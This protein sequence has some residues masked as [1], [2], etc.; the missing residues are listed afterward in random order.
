[1]ERSTYDPSS[2]VLLTNVCTAFCCLGSMRYADTV[3]SRS[4]TPDAVTTPVRPDAPRAASMAAIAS[5]LLN[6]QT[7]EGVIGDLFLGVN[8]RIRPRGGREHE[9]L[10]L[11]GRSI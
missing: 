5:A 7:F 1:M 2:P 11:R 10:E 4:G 6:A 8:R 9:V 3:Q